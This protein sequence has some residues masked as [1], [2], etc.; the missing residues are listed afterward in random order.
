MVVLIPFLS[1]SQFP[2]AFSMFCSLIMQRWDNGLILITKKV[3]FTMNRHS[4]TL[5]N[6]IIER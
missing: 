2:E 5:K 4:Q 3:A 1:D 6:F